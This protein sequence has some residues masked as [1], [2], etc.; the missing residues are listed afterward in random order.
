[1]SR[2]KKKIE[3]DARS[4]KG[5]PSE[6]LVV[7]QVDPAGDLT[8]LEPPKPPYVRRKLFGHS[9]CIGESVA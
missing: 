9:T 3:C 5:K 7:L 8:A 2:G 6:W 4:R 1:M